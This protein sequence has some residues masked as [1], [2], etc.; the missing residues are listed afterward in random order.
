MAGTVLSAHPSGRSWCCLLRRSNCSMRKDSLS[1][2]EC[3]D[4]RECDVRLDADTWL[5]RRESSIA[6]RMDARRASR[7]NFEGRVHRRISSEQGVTAF[8]SSAYGRLSDSRWT[9]GWRSAWCRSCLASF[10]LSLLGF[11]RRRLIYG[12]PGRLKLACNTTSWVRH[13]K[14]RSG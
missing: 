6:R 10:I 13:V 14:P 11:E 8:E 5:P 9:N 4:R 7:E 1:V 12:D 3:G 2:G